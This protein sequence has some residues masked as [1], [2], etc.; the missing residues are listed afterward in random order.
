MQNTGCFPEIPTKY[1]LT[2]F[3]IKKG[4]HHFNTY[5]GCNFKLFLVFKSYRTNKKEPTM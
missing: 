3:L 5:K 1:I 2:Y 4:S